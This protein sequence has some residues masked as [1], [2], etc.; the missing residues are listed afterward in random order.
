M[1]YLQRSRCTAATPTKKLSCSCSAAGA[2]WQVQKPRRLRLRSIKYIFLS[3]GEQAQLTRRSPHLPHLLIPRTPLPITPTKVQIRAQYVF[4]PRVGYF[5]VFSAS[6]R[7][8]STL[9]L[10]QLESQRL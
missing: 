5:I 10:P 6:S 8:V 7:L 2:K 1:K 3:A 4:S 9:P